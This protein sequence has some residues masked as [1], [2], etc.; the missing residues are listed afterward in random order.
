MFINFECLNQWI[1]YYLSIFLKY[2]LNHILSIYCSSKKQ[3]K[4]K[5]KKKKKKDSFNTFTH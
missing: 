4:K 2:H 3:K 1:L 5:K